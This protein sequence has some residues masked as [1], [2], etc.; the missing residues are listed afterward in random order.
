MRT[1][2]IQIRRYIILF[3][4]RSQKNIFH[5]YSSRNLAYFSQSYKEHDLNWFVY[6]FNKQNYIVSSH[7]SGDV[8]YVYS[9]LSKSFYFLRPILRSKLVGYVPGCQAASCQSFK[10]ELNLNNCF[11]VCMLGIFAWNAKKSEALKLKT[12]NFLANSTMCSLNRNV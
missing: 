9:L 12:V 5:K 7:S 4:L 11:I 10:A 6:C 2:T 8:I 1:V 3:W